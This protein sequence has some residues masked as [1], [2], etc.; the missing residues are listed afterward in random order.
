MEPFV[1]QSS[2]YFENSNSFNPVII[3]E[4][5]LVH[6]IATF[7]IILRL[8]EVKSL[9]QTHIVIHQDLNRESPS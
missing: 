9:A 2:K 6:F 4:R 1:N 5:Q 3:R 8:R 7:L